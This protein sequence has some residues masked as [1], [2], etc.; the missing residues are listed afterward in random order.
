MLLLPH[1]MASPL[2]WL[3]AHDLVSRLAAGETTSAELVEL[4]LGQIERHNRR[5][6]GLHAVI[7]ARPRD[8]AVAEAARLDGERRAGRVR[9]RL[10]GMPI[11]LKVSKDGLLDIVLVFR[12][13][14]RDQDL[15]V[16]K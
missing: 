3:P 4:C 5:G 12:C 2:L 11:V 6:L 7:A 9:S 15:S 1:P 8:D 14:A 13:A 10:H 16:G